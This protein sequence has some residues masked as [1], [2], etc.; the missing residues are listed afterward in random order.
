MDEAL[1]KINLRQSDDSVLQIDPDTIPN[2][3]PGKILKQWMDKDDNPHFKIQ[4]IEYPLIANRYNYTESFFESFIGK[5]NS[6]PIPGSKDG[7]ETSWGKRGK[8]DI[9]LIGAKI[10]KTGDGTGTVFFK[11]YFPPEGES[12]SNEI[13]IRESKSDMIEFSLVSYTKDVREEMPDGSVN[14]NVIES[15]YGERNDIVSYA[16][17]AMLQKTNNKIIDKEENMDK[18][19]ILK[20]LLTLKTNNGVTLP[21]IAKHL[22]LEDLIIT[23]EQKSSLSKMNAVITICGDSDPVE[24]INGLVKERKEN[25]DAIRAAKLNEVFGAR[26]V[27]DKE[28]KARIYADTL[29]GDMELT[30]EKINEIKEDSIFKTLASELADVDSDF[31]KIGISDK[32]ENATVESEYFVAKY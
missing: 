10:D 1:K 6:R 8:T 22:N 12:G 20:S 32:K 16:E 5:L 29:I 28:N 23:D 15:M 14:Y 21:E 24:F 4:K 11:N 2:L 18:G 13:L 31:N 7:H 25:S 30:E 27:N 9:L 3:V 17:G 19:E 26:K